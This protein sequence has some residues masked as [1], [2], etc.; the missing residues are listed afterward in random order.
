MDVVLLVVARC[1]HFLALCIA[2]EIISAR[3]TRINF[4]VITLS[5]LAL[6][7]AR[8]CSGA[9]MGSVAAIAIIAAMLL[10]VTAALAVLGRVESE[11]LFACTLILDLALVHWMIDARNPLT[12]GIDGQAIKTRVA[13]LSDSA[14]GVYAMLAALCG[15]VVCRE[16]FSRSRFG[17]Q[18]FASV[19]DPALAGLWGVPWKRGWS[20]AV[21]STWACLLIACSIWVH[22][23]SR[24]Q[25]ASP[26]METMLAAVV[27][28]QFSR[29][30][31]LP[32][33]AIALV[34]GGAMAF[35]TY[36]SSSVL[37]RIVIGTC[38]LI[39]ISRWSCK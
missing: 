13:A 39:V 12:N 7:A 28:V 18:A 35:S 10:V 29:G 24:L 32:L 31:G 16:A 6:F 20:V 27:A 2:L 4:C 3:G 19:T 9:D 23:V 15:L 14:N 1:V 5:S 26:G 25:P 8:A 34:V 30:R 33:Y 11:R 36:V 22:S 37:E 38:G 21:L 17:M